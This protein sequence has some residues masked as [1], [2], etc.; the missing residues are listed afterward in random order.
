MFL[1]ISTSFVHPKSQGKS[2]IRREVPV[3]V[4]YDE[5]ELMMTITRLNKN[6][7][8]RVGPL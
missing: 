2:T 4:T 5:E 3:P 7:R 1:Y 8:N 6:E